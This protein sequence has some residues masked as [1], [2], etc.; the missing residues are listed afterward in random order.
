VGG[1]SIDQIDRKNFSH[2]IAMVP[3][4]T[5]IFDGSILD[6]I[7]LWDPEITVEQVYT[8]CQLCSIHDEIINLPK[9]YKSILQED[10]ADLSGGQKQRIALAR[11]VVRSPKLLILDEATS[12]LDAR[13]EAKILKNLRES[14]MT[15][16]FATHRLSNLRFSDK[17]LFMQ[18]GSIL[19]T[20][21]HQQLINLG[22]SYASLVASASEVHL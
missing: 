6:N 21:T 19:E 15:L 11:A 7:T 22:G 2:S 13:T 17:I 14:S 18:A 1:I 5:Q 20:G 12:A 4:K 10:G 8:A 16:L 9:G 3:Q